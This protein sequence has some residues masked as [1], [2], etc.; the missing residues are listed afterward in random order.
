MRIRFVQTTPSKA[1]GYPFQPGQV[2]ELTYNDD[3]RVWLEYG[4]A[5]VLPDEGEE[6]AVLGEPEA[7]A[8]MTRP[9]PRGKR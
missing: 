8:V 7:V 2:I 1:G 9:R 3:V 5:V 4:F 6:A